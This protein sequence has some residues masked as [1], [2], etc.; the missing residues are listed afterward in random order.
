[1]LL[2]KPFITLTSMVKRLGMALGTML[3]L[4]MDSRVLSKGMALKVMD[5]KEEL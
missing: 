4:V 1:M 2:I 3:M 5:L